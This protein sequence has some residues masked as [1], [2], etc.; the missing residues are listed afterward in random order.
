M[1]GHHIVIAAWD[2]GRRKGEPY[3]RMYEA[4]CDP[5]RWRSEHTPY[6]WQVR[7]WA[8]VHEGKDPPPP[9]KRGPG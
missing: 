4:R 5:C 3:V 9:W 7:A 8:D 1:T 6:L 2:Q